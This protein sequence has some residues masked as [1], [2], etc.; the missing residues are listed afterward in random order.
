MKIYKLISR[1]WWNTQKLS[2]YVTQFKNV[3]DMRLKSGVCFLYYMNLLCLTQ[4]T[5]GF[6][7]EIWGCEVS[8]S[9]KKCQT[10]NENV[11]VTCEIWKRLNMSKYTSV[12]LILNKVIQEGK[13]WIVNKYVFFNNS[14]K[15]ILHWNQEIK[16]YTVLASSTFV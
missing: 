7:K 13:L 11:E 6:I 1:K 5:E 15:Q 4:S 10:S 8:Q 9:K 14:Y 2:L 3:Y 16:D 12:I